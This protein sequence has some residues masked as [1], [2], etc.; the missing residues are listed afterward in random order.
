MQLGPMPV[1]M[2]RAR[3]LNLPLGPDYKTQWRFYTGPVS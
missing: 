2:I 3:L 1:E